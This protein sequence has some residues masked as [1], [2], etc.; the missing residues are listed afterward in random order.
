MTSTA[1]NDELRDACAA[2]QDGRD[3]G[4]SPI[5]AA[6]RVLTGTKHYFEAD[7][8]DRYERD[9]S[10]NALTMARA[11]TLLAAL[12]TSPTRDG[13]GWAERTGFGSGWVGRGIK[14]GAQD[15]QINAAL[16]T[17]FITMPLWG[18]SLDR[19]VAR[20]YGSAFLFQIEGPFP[21]LP[22]WEASGLKSDERELITGGRYAVT[23]VARGPE[24][25][26]VMLHFLDLVMPAA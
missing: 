19:D 6:A 9:A 5:R 26:V 24:G 14:S 20:S 2:W 16:N 7:F 25:V 18:L 13:E 8:I 10:A 11:Q 21:A 17:G 3:G 15:P 23:N 12:A 4:S 22:A 1:T